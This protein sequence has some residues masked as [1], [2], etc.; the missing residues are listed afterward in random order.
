MPK[1][2][3]FTLEQFGRGNSMLLNA[4]Y[5]LDIEIRK[6]NAGPAEE[7]R[8]AEPSTGSFYFADVLT[9][10][11]YQSHADAV[12]AAINGGSVLKHLVSRGIAVSTDSVKTGLMKMRKEL[13]QD[14]RK[15]QAKRKEVA[16]G[17]IRKRT[18]RCSK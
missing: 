2:A 5:N 4:L 18:R 6:Q 12:V 9:L 8:F 17:Y 16:S 10:E 11:M 1:P 15:R 13:L 3:I 7:R 14:L